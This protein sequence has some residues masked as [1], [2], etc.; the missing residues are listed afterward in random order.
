MI[1]AASSDT[2]GFDCCGLIKGI[3]WGWSGDKS[4]T[5]GG[6]TY[7]SNGVPDDSADTIITKCTDVSTDFTKIEV[8]E[9]VWKKGHIGVYIGDGL[10]IESTPAWKN[11]VQITACNCSK[12]GYNR[13]NWTKHGK[14]PYVEYTAEEKDTV[15]ADFSI[16]MRTLRRGDS[17]EDVRALQILLAGR[18]CNGDMNKPDGK[19]GPNTEGAVKLYQNKTGLDDDGVAGP[20]TWN[21]ILGI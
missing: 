20:K 19:F 3:L 5:Y 13:R 15:K 9:A 2:F 17:G 8:G 18:G 14:L 10:A 6:A 7:K 12:S 11:G 16:G 21:K 1:K 4:K